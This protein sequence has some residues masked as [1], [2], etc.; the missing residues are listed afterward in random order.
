MAY[1]AGN[2]VAKTNLGWTN[3]AKTL[4]MQNRSRAVKQRSQKLGGRNRSGLNRAGAAEQ[5]RLNQRHT[6]LQNRWQTQIR[7]EQDTWGSQQ[8][9]CNKAAA[10]RVGN[11]VAKSNQGWSIEA[12]TLGVRNSGSVVKQ[13]HAGLRTWWHR[14]I[15]AGAVDLE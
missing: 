2:S 8:G 12:K 9:L 1:K 11:S 15:R 13:R 4:G 10:E 3:R 6:E 5:K 7:L 14:Q